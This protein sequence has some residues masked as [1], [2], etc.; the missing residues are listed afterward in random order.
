MKLR[1]PVIKKKLVVKIT[2]KK[3]IKIVNEHKLDKMETDEDFKK[4]TG[5]TREEFSNLPKWR[6]QNVKKTAKIF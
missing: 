4:G 6:Q 3:C 1:R 2:K 5:M